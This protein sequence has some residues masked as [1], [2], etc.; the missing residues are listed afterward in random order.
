MNILYVLRDHTAAKY[1]QY[2]VLASRKAGHTHTIL[3]DPS[4]K[5]QE[6]LTS[7]GLEFVDRCSV[8]NFD[9]IVSGCSVPAGIEQEII[10]EAT[11]ETKKVILFPDNWCK[12]TTRVVCKPNL[13][14][15][16]DEINAQINSDYR[17]LIVG[18]PI[19]ME[20]IKEDGGFNKSI[21]VAFQSE[22]S[23]KAMVAVLKNFDQLDAYSIFPRVHP[24]YEDKLWAQELIE[25]IFSNCPNVCK[26]KKT[27]TTVLEQNCEISISTFSGTLKNASFSGK[28]A[29][30]A[31]S[32]NAKKRMIESTGLDYYPLT[33]YGYATEIWEG[34]KWGLND[35]KSIPYLPPKFEKE[36]YL[37]LLASV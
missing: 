21:L 3:A 20:P 11:V 2:L 26:D 35:L 18:D 31:M 19:G 36:K 23:S 28:Y 25:E 33:K 27:S 32:E 14:L 7:V 5:G 9:L 10:N 17:T 8:K 24:K 4:G 1:L 34:K 12:A 30:S 13:I 6:C 29:I 37:E 22:E 15:C 16:I